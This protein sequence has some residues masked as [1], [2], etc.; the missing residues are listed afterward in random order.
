L[1]ERDQATGAFRP[2]AI[3]IGGSP[4]A[5]KIDD[6][7]RKA[8]E[9]AS[10]AYSTI[11]KMLKHPGL[12]TAVGMSGQ[13]DPRNKI[14]GTDAQGALALIDQAQGQAFLQAF[15]SLKGGG[16]ITEIEGVKATQAIARLQR[17]QNERDF[18][19][20]AKELMDLA[21]MGHKRATGRALSGGPQVPRI[22]S[23]ADYAALPS[24][25]TYVDPNGVTRKKP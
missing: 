15:E 10:R 20:A 11:D 19:A 16:H 7:K 13:I 3:P 6:D 24:G 17:S 9:A 5:R 2:V 1:T 8:A 23:S 4:D 21:D 18:R 25:A 12:D 14:W 22:S